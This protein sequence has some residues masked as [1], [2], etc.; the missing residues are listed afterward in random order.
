MLRK[1]LMK[2]I[3]GGDCLTRMTK[4]YSEDSNGIARP[5]LSIY[6]KSI[7]RYPLLDEETERNLAE[8]IKKSEKECMNLIVRWGRL[9]KKELLTLLSDKYSKGMNSTVQ[10]ADDCSTLFDDII[11]L[12]RERKKVARLLSKGCQYISW[13]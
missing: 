7:N 11:T 8:M 2:K 6:F 13:I 1:R 10:Q 3:N 5:A 9:F 12:E 4:I